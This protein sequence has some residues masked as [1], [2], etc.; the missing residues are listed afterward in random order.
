MQ[1]SA[2]AYKLHQCCSINV[3]AISVKVLIPLGEDI[4]QFS[5]VAVFTVPEGTQ[6]ALNKK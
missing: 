6:C 5:Q 4:L 2:R 3:R 1:L